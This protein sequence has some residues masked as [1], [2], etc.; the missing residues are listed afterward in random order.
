MVELNSYAIQHC[1]S[2]KF[3]FLFDNSKSSTEFDKNTLNEWM[4]KHCK[5][6][7]N[8]ANLT[9]GYNNVKYEYFNVQFLYDNYIKNSEVINLLGDNIKFYWK[10]KY[11]TI[12]DIYKNAVFFIVDAHCLYALFDIYF[13]FFISA[14]YNEVKEVFNKKKLKTIKKNLSKINRSIQL[15]PNNFPEKLKYLISDINK[16]LSISVN[17]S[18][19][20]GNLEIGE[21]KFM[22]EVNKIKR[23][24]DEQFRK[25]NI[26]FEK[27]FLFQ[28]IM[29]GIKSI[30]VMIFS[31]EAIQIIN[32]DISTNLPSFY[33]YFI[34]LNAFKG[35]YKAGQVNTFF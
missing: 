24:I 14:I 4:S 33:K 1:T 26:I 7:F 30:R 35:S 22:D 27:N 9:G 21:T 17:E 32:K 2:S 8:I 28:I 19:I 3:N 16:L 20:N 6:C 12:V 25:F 13:K 5:N 23:I 10:G 11:R 15:V 31:N 18:N 34:D 29:R